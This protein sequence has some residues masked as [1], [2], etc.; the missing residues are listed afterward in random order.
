DKLAF[1]P[2]VISVL[3]K[4]HKAGFK[5]VMISNQDGIGTQIFPKADFDGSRNQMMQIFTSQGLFFDEELTCAHLPAEA[6]DCRK[7]KVKLGERYLA[8]Q[9]MDSATSY[10][11]G[12]RST[13]VQLADI[14]GITA[15]R[16]HRETL[17]WTTIGEKLTKRDRYAH[18]VR[19]TKETEL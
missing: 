1:E 13:T 10:V 7:P 19:N 8:E 16:Y 9:A 17:N 2:E 14:M 5:L 3:L 6:C 11:I 12:D 15:L 18:G 4:E